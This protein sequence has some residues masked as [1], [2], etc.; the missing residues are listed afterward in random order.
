MSDQKKFGTFAGVF[1]PA[2][3]T[4][5]GVIMYLRL[6]WTVGSLGL[7]KAIVVI[8]LAHIVTLTT[9]LSLASLATNVRVGAGGF[10]AFISRSLG[11]EAGGAIGIPLYISQA[12]SISFYIM[13]FSE[14]WQLLFPSHNHLVVLLSVLIFMALLSFIGAN[15]ALKMQY[16]IMILIILS[17]VS[18]FLSP[19]KIDDEVQLFKKGVGHADFWFVFAVFFPAVTGIG[20]GVAMS[21]DLKNPKKSLPLGILA[22]IGTGFIIYMA[23]AIWYAYIASAE[24]LT[25]DFYV[26]I[27]YSRFPILVI[28]GLMGATV[29]SALGSLVGAPRIL[30][31]LANDRV[32]PLSSIFSKMSKNGTPR[33]ATLLTVMIVIGSLFLGDLDSI[34]ALLTMFFLITYAVINFTVFVE[35]LIR[36]PSFRPSFNVPMI[37]PA[38]GILWC[39]GVMFLINIYFAITAYIVI[40][41]LYFIYV[42]RGLNAPFG[43]VRSGIFTALAE[44]AVRT[45][46]RLPQHQKTWKPD[47]IVPVQNDKQ[48]SK[49]KEFVQAIV[50]PGGSIRLVSVNETDFHGK[51]VISSVINRYLK[52]SDKDKRQYLK[53]FPG[54]ED[55]FLEL[56][57][58]KKELMSEGVFS[59]ATVVDAVSFLEGLSIVIQ[60]SRGMFFPPNSILLSMSDDPKKDVRLM[61]ILAI[62]VRE[63][64]GVILLNCNSETGFGDRKSVNI[65]LRVDSP[66]KNLAVLTGLQL[67]KNWRCKLRLVSSVLNDQEYDHAVTQLKEVKELGRLHANTRITVIRKSFREALDDVSRADLNIFGISQNVDIGFIR[68]ISSS[69][70]GS[71]LFI[72][73]SGQERIDV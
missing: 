4:I 50:N 52:T 18:F 66:N 7:G 53:H 25:E 16:I 48:W 32:I 33:T 39:T 47:L 12:L 9:G 56:D 31:A 29:S 65:W 55:R 30:Q 6:G 14:A 69:V 10:Y 49:R 68:N 21:G 45:S 43:D 22:A 51:N 67:G 71:S 19:I 20:S 57:H 11:A 5:L 23:L 40:V 38:A 63:K 35:K 2:V 41:I 3:L 15:S 1:T 34:A 54:F 72:M 17:I 26:M 46:F 70:S 13:G 59:T 62:S 60:T 73:D 58:I 8:L 37:I 36:I 61:E 28:L 24:K 64:L 42:R 44:W 27:V